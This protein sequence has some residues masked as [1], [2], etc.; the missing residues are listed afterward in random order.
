MRSTMPLRKLLMRLARVVVEEE[1]VYPGFAVRLGAVLVSVGQE[2]EAAAAPTAVQVPAAVPSPIQVA[3]EVASAV[4]A[5]A[6]AADADAV[7]TLRARSPKTPL[8]DVH[9]EFA[10]L[11]DEG[12]RIWLR[13][14]AVDT[15]RA[16]IRRE[17]MD[18]ARRA[19]RWKDVGRLAEFIADALEVRR[20]RGAAFIGREPRGV[21][22]SL[23]GMDV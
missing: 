1:A 13:S 21:S 14:L 4:P 16:I 23:D 18:A 3:A 9:K 22:G 19:S 8:P 20:N 7:P 2:V 6:A 12:L 11:G 17:D 10:K 5:Y 15:L